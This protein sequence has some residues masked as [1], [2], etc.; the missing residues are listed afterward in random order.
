[1]QQNK[2]LILDVQYKSMSPKYPINTPKDWN[3]FW[4][5]LIIFS[6]HPPPQKK[7]KIHHCQ[8]C[9]DLI[10]HSVRFIL[11]KTLYNNISSVIEMVS[12]DVISASVFSRDTLHMSQEFK[13][14]LFC[15][16]GISPEVT[17]SPS[18]HRY[19]VDVCISFSVRY[20]ER[21]RTSGITH[22]PLD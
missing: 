11:C 18:R 20:L 6:L 15:S 17:F 12:A 21:S 9:I 3:P 5:R 10:Y 7:M 4:S 8:L 16:K 19:T 14:P 13:V 22:P 1:M 2:Q